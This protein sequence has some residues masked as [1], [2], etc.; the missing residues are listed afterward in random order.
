[1]SG[2]FVVSTQVGG[3]GQPAFKVGT[4]IV[5]DGAAIANFASL[6]IQGSTRIDSSGNV[7]TNDCNVFGAVN[8]QGSTASSASGGSASALP[9]NPAGYVFAKLGGSSIKIPYYFV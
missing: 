5:I 8:F 1:V 4:S 7:T 6:Q 3:V 9:A 2:N